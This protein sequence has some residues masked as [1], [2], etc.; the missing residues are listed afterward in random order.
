MALF[1]LFG[2]FVCLLILEAVVYLGGFADDGRDP[3]PAIRGLFVVTLLESGGAGP[4]AWIHALE[5]I[6]DIGVNLAI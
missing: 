1:G 5:D 6:V 2:A 3:R 4:S